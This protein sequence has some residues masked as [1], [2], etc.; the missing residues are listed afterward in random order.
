M[1]SNFANTPPPNTNTGGGDSFGDVQ[2]WVS[3]CTR[4]NVP[5]QLG[6][7][8][9]YT[10]LRLLHPVA[11]HPVRIVV[12]A[13]R[14]GVVSSRDGTLCT[15]LESGSDVGCGLRAVRTAS[16]SGAG[17]GGSNGQV[18]VGIFH[19]IPKCLTNV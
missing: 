9:M 5:A 15:M 17:A 3:L 4:Q 2:V 1:R 8:T 6:H 14:V 7:V 10:R 12:V 11:L 18:G 19:D 13:A 16:G